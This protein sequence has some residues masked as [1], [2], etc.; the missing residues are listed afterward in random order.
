MGVNNETLYLKIEQ[1]TI[2][3]D[4]HV[5]LNDIAKMECTNEA[6]LR[7]LKQKKI[8]SFTDRKDEKK[9]KNQMQ[10]FS[11]LKIIEQIHEDY[12]SLTISNEGES[13]FI[14]EYVPDPKKPKVINAVKTV[15]LCIIIFFGSAFTIMAFNND[16]SVTDVFDKLYGQVMGIKAGGVTELEVCYCIGLGLGIILFFNHVGRKKITPDP[17]PIQ[18]E[19]RKYEKDVD[20]TF[21]ENAGRGGHS[22]DVS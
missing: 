15:L 19:M 4:R 8:Y 20:T 17:T 2:V 9:Q 12:P 1:N 11:V 3:F 14:I 5:V 7:Q 13:D 22:I 16:I 10:V 6:V 18:I 21:I